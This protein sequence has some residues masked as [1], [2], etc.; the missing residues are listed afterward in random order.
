MTVSE[1]EQDAYARGCADTVRVGRDMVQALRREE[2]LTEVGYRLLAQ[3][4][5]EFLRGGR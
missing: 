5:L 4:D 2:K 1:A 3:L